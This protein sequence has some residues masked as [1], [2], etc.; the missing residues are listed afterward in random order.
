MQCFIEI[1]S[2]LQ[3]HEPLQII[4]WFHNE[5]IKI[6]HKNHMV[7]VLSTALMYSSILVKFEALTIII[8]LLLSITQIVFLLSTAP[9]T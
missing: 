2:K 8:N 4:F 7:A 3:H 9:I 5:M 6:V 1:L